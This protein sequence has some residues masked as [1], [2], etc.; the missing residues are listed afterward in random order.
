MRSYPR[1]RRLRGEDY[2]TRIEFSISRAE[3]GRRNLDRRIDATTMTSR[4]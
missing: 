4:L 1:A 2:K 3:T